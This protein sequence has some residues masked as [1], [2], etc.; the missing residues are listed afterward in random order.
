MKKDIAAHMAA[1]LKM[2]RE[3][4]GLTVYEVGE[5]IGKSGETVSAWENGRGKPDAD[6]FLVLCEL[7]HVESVGVFYGEEVDAAAELIPEERE[8]IELWRSLNEVGKSAVL[9]VMKNPDFQKDVTR[10]TAI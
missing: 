8:V 3:S 10:K 1:T 9:S 7:Y 6:T 5:K 4:V 2:Y